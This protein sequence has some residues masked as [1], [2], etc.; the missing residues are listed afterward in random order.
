MHRHEAKASTVCCKNTRNAIRAPQ[1]RRGRSVVPHRSPVNGGMGI[2]GSFR[3]EGG[4][5]TSSVTEQ[6]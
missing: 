1:G 2:S 3:P 5:P 6:L 4:C